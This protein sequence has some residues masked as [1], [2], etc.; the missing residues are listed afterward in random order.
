MSTSQL[1][2]DFISLPARTIAIGFVLCGIISFS[3]TEGMKRMTIGP[4]FKGNRH[5]SDEDITPTV[6]GVKI[7]TCSY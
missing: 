2:C 5:L 3:S 4:E 7:L 1:I 6:L